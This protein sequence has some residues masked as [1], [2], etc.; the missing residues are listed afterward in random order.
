[1]DCV[2]V[3]I[4]SWPDSISR[5]ERAGAVLQVKHTTDGVVIQDEE[6]LK[7][8]AEPLEPICIAQYA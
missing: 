2:S 8:V 1:M 6:G 5:V 3:E 4:C 7:S